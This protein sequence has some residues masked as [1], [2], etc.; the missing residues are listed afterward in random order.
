M[1]VANLHSSVQF[2]SDF[3][4][5]VGETYSVDDVLPRMTELLA[6]STGASEARVWLRSESRL[7][8]VASSPTDAPALPSVMLAGEDLPSFGGNQSAF[9]VS[10]QGEL[11]GA[12]TLRMP[13]N[14]PMDPG[15]EGTAGARPGLTSRP[16]ASQ[17]RTR[18]G[19]S[20]ESAPDRRRARRTR[21]GA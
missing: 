6:G 11:L 16:R 18:P 21:E 5:R 9:P 4:E 2:L 17:R 1:I 12:I 20:G 7:T 19:S 14:D 10:H 13:L 8:P 15:K 3:S